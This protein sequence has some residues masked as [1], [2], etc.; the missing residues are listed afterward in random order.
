[1][2]LL[3]SVFL[4]NSYIFRYRY[5]INALSFSH[6]GEYLAIANAGTY[7]D[8]VSPSNTLT[9]FSLTF[10]QFANSVPLKPAFPSTAFPL[11]LLPLQ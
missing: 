7:I 6:D 3:P 1:M 10:F 11:W 5:S 9:S 2:S 8:I 4:K